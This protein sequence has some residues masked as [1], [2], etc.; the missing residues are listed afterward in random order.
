M[1]PAAEQDPT[2]T[3][4]P[5]GGGE[6]G[7]RIRAFDWSTTA[8]G[9]LAHW[10]QGLK[11]ALQIMLNSPHPMF[12]C[13]GTERL[14]FYNDAQR[15]IL[16][17]RH[18]GALGRPVAEVWVALWPVLAPQF[19]AALDPA[20]GGLEL[21]LP[22]GP[23]PARRQWRYLCSPLPGADDTPQ[24]VC[25]VHADTPARDAGTAPDEHQQRLQVFLANT[26]SLMGV[27]ELATDDED[28][29]HVFDNLATEIF[30]GVG[31]GGSAGR[32]A[33]RELGVP[34][35]AVREWSAHY[36]E[37][38]RTGQA[39]R[40]PFG[41]SPP[42][43]AGAAAPRRHWLDVSVSHMGPGEQDRDR[44]CYTAIDDTERRWAEEALRESEQRFRMM[45]DNLPLI[46]WLHDAEGRQSFVNQTFCDYFQVDRQEMRD[47]RWQMLTH[48]EDGPRYIQ[49]FLHSVRGRT[50]FHAE[51][52]VKQ[53]PD[54]EW[55][56]LESWGQPRFDEHGEYLGHVGTSADVT[57]RK[58]AEAA[59]YQANRRKDEFLAILAHELRNPLAPLR[60]G[61][62]LLQLVENEPAVAVQARTMMERQFAHLVRLIDDLLDVSRISRG[63][64]TLRRERVLLDRV[65]ENV[66]ESARPL[67]ARESHDLKVQLPGE[68]LALDA[69]AARLQQIFINLLDNA[70]KFTQGGG[71][72]RLSATRHGD[73]VVVT[74]SDDGIGIDPGRLSEIFELF[75]QVDQSLEKMRNG[76]GIGLS[77]AKG[78]VELH[79]G[80]IQVHSDGPG[81]GSE[82]V[83]RLPLSPGTAAAQSTETGAD[84]GGGGHKRRVLVV[85]DNVDAATSLAML[86]RVM[87]HDTRTAHDGLEGLA[88][89]EEFRP[90]V[91]LLDLGMPR[92]NGYDTARRLR[93]D[94]WGRELLLGA[95]TGWGQEENRRQSREAGFD[96][97]LVKPVE[98]AVLARVLATGS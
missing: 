30:L 86:L 17:E 54:G 42:A 75:T 59:L 37:S 67:M 23:P 94:A 96:L 98:P 62:E 35:A 65:L 15:E 41:Y 66:V 13:W 82:F 80:S 34:E 21:R 1:T 33:H 32:W 60:S 20:Q 69:D 40:F 63:R 88:V 5:T 51:V 49:A 39:V 84:A 78:L 79:G 71:H 85:D 29:L 87:G 46:I 36:R 3:V 14:H 9:T 52:R 77:L 89:A 91:V 31:A 53:H 50:R 10:P 58:Q 68:P 25:C 26:P 18:P 61:L 27:V 74:V 83:V 7:E 2:R 43:G 24:G 70:A 45:A 95:L 64:I 57:E 8:L 4:F 93:A 16:D 19:E 11:A 81:R 73:E 55:R 12:I 90:E 48:P 22:G 6:M 28:I 47:Q 38:R 56:W 92:L 76:L 72:I 44:Y 97:H